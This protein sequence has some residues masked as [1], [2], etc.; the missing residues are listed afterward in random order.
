MAIYFLIYFV[1]LIYAIREDYK[2]SPKLRIVILVILALFLCTGYMTGSDWRNYEY[3]TIINQNAYEIRGPEFGF[4]WLVN[5]PTSNG[6]DFWILW[7]ILKIFCF[8]SLIKSLKYFIGIK[9]GWAL[10][11]FYAY[12][13]LFYFIDNPMRNLIA[14]SIFVFSYKYIEQHDLKKYCIICFFAATMHASTLLIFPIYFIYKKI[15]RLSTSKFII[16]P[17]IFYLSLLVFYLTGMNIYINIFL[18]FIFGDSFRGQYYLNDDVNYISLGL[19]FT[20]VMYVYV[21]INRNII[22]TVNKHGKFLIS[23]SFV[24]I[25]SLMVGFF[26]PILYRLIMFT[27]IP[28]IASINI[29]MYNKRADIIKIMTKVTLVVFLGIVMKKNITHDF[30]YIPYTSYLEYIGKNKPSYQYR[31]SYNLDNSPYK[32]SILDN[33]N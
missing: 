25:C 14:A 5:F 32:K 2:L 3:M 10:L 23:I 26:I 6:I 1:V 33:D 22:E 19:V 24:F 16:V 15:S 20:Y 11:Y 18:S 28:F 31:S 7:I 13:S 8:Y 9:D 29:I 30:R 27:F 21:I 17:L 4:Y 12:F